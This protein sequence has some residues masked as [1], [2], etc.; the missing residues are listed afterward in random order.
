MYIISIQDEGILM[1][2]VTVS[3]LNIM[4]GKLQQRLPI[5]TYH[6]IGLLAQMTK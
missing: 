5:H 4:L 1:T 3:T 6:I 2:P